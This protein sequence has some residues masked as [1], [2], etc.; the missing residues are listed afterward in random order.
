ML[1]ARWDKKLAPLFRWYRFI[2]R[3]VRRA[4]SML[5][6]YLDQLFYLVGEAVVFLAVSVLILS[7][8]S[9]SAHP[10]LL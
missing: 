1:I 7:V 9:G 5:P 2:N 3:G 10:L 4:T 8:L 6:E